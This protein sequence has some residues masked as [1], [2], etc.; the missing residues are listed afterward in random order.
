MVRHDAQV[1]SACAK[2]IKALAGKLA[3]ARTLLDNFDFAGA[4]P[5]LAAINLKAA[6]ST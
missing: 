5:L 6:A 4:E 3:T 1:Q 2:Q